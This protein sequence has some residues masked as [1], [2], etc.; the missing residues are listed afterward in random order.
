MADCTPLIR[1]IAMPADT[2]PHG[3][4]FGG[5]LMGQI[6]L[7]YGSFASGQAGGKAALS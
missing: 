5:W 1:V 2:N 7:G 3:G 6:R 4:V